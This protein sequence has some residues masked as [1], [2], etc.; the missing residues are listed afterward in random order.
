MFPNDFRFEGN[1]ALVLPLKGP[2]PKDALAVCVAVAL[3][4]HRK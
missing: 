4:Y 2:M 1:R 3:T